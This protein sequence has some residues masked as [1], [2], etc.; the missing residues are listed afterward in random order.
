MI[1]WRLRGTKVLSLID[2]SDAF[3][4]V[5]LA[6]SGTHYFNYKLIAFVLCI[7]G[8]TLLLT[9]D[10]VYLDDI[11]IATEHHFGFFEKLANRI[12]IAGLTISSEQ[13]HDIESIKYL[14]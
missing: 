3:L 10:F 9:Y 7:S 5:P 14:A 11:I 4:Q 6:I 12:S 2:F 1:L 8:A 13:I